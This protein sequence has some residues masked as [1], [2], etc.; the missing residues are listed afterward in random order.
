MAKIIKVFFLLTAASLFPAA[1]LADEGGELLWWMV[2]DVGSISGKDKDGNVHSASELGVQKARVRYDNG[3]GES[4]YLTLWSLDENN[5]FVQEAD[6]AAGVGLP[7]EYYGSLAGL[8]GDSASYSFVIELGNW[9]DGRWT[10][11]M[12]SESVNYGYLAAQKHIASWDN[13]APVDSTCWSP[14]SYQVIPEPDGAL[15][16]LLGGA[17]L[18]LRRRHGAK[19]AG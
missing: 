19:D 2:G 7:A 9:S 11:M 4:G 6:S 16:L 3:S 17:L 15:L 5:D 12:E 14:S 1:V 8:S 13:I 10:G 18:S